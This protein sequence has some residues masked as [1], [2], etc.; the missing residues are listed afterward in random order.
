MSEKDKL[1]SWYGD[2]NL[3]LDFYGNG[4][5]PTVVYTDQNGNLY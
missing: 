1:N 3:G 5:Y 4:N 2:D